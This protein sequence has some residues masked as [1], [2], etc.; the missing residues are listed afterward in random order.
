MTLKLQNSIYANQDVQKKSRLKPL[1]LTL[2][3][4]PQDPPYSIALLKKT[5]APHQ[6]IVPI[7]LLMGLL[8]LLP[9]LGILKLSGYIISQWRFYE[10]AF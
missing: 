9:F 8:P 1:S 10:E 5:K 2:I 4:P 7:A 3:K 6:N